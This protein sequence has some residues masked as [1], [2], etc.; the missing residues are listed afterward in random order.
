MCFGILLLLA[1]KVQFGDVY[2]IFVVGNFMLYLLFNLMSQVETI[3]LYNIMSA[4][5]Y[6]MIPMLILG[7]VG[8]FISMKGPIGIG[9]S[10]GVSGWSSFAA[11]TFI[12][13]LMKQTESNRKI[14]LLYPLF[15][16]YVSFAM[17]IIF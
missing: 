17:I 14:L 10:L 1:G 4:M 2:A 5:G 7:L 11:S 15:L 3:S 8:I 12:E 6:S 16:F 13:G 9:V